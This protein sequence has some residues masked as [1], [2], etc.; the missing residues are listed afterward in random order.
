MTVCFTV[1]S[2][3]YA[4]DL[5]RD[6][7]LEFIIYGKDVACIIQLRCYY[8][9]LIKNGGTILKDSHMPISVIVPKRYS[10]GSQRIPKKD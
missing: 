5:F 7:I 4:Y 2:K 6:Y 10:H 9:H 1:Y 3:T 8:G